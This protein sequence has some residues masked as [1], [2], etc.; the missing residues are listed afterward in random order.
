MSSKITENQTFDSQ[1]VQDLL[2]RLD[3]EYRRAELAESRLAKLSDALSM[4]KQYE[5]QLAA[6]DKEKKELQDARMSTRQ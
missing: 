5:K 4:E 2:R 6:K 3:A 1:F